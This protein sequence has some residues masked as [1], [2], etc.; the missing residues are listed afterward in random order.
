METNSTVVLLLLLVAG[1]SPIMTVVL[2]EL[3]KIFMEKRRGGSP[4]E[5]EHAREQAKK[6]KEVITKHK[7]SY[8]NDIEALSR[9][10]WA[11]SSN[12]WTGW[13]K[14][15]GDHEAAMKNKQIVLF[16]YRTI[17]VL[18][19]T[20][21]IDFELSYCDTTLAVKRDMDFIR[22]I[23]LLPQTL[24]EV[25]LYRGLN[26]DA[27]GAHDYFFRPDLEKMAETLVKAEK[28]RSF[29]EF[30]SYLPRY[31]K[32]LTPM[33]EFIDDITPDEARLRWDRL[34]IFHL[35]LI[36]ILNDFGFDFQKTADDRINYLMTQPRPI[37]VLH[38]FVGLVE[39]D[40]MDKIPEIKRIVKLIKKANV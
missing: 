5:A 29:G 23:R 20:K 14:I 8:L 21:K 28:I 15:Q 25:V 7:V 27:S 32:R 38:N 3:V 10:L 9:T 31:C 17:A 34:K 13:H 16:M 22:Y 37:K 2:L 11:L 39:R 6:I 24:Y 33:C 26:Q 35:V 12:Y 1:L 4:I 18:A 36:A 19:W 40:K 30:E